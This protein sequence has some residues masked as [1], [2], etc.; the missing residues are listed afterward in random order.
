MSKAE[1]LGTDDIGALLLKQGLPASIG[2]LTLSIYFIV[3]TI[4]V[5][6]Y[7]GRLGIA[8]ITVVL[9]ITFLISSVGMA[10]GVGGATII[11]RA[12]G[13]N[14]KEKAQL[15]LGNQLALSGILG[16]LFVLLFF[17]FRD[18]LLL[19]FG[20]QGAIMPYAKTYFEVLI[21][22]VFPL[23]FA[24]ML[25]NVL[26]AEGK[27]KFAMLVMIAP[28]VTNVA[29]DFLFIAYFEWGI[30]GA[31]WATNFAYLIS[32]SMAVFFFVS[33]RTELYPRLNDIC[34]EGKII[35][36]IISI[37]SIT[38]ARQATISLLSL[39]LNNS[40][41]SLGGD[42]AVATWGIINRSMMFAIFPVLGVTQGF[43]PIV[44]Y[45][46]GAR[47]WA[48]VREVINKA[49]L[50]AFLLGGI[51]MLGIYYF[52]DAIAP[53]FSSDQPLIEASPN[54]I[55]LCFLAVPLVG[56][57]LISSAYFQAIGK[58]FPALI[59]TL[60]RQGFL[61]IPLLLL[62]PNFFG[63]NGIWYSFPL[64]DSLSALICFA[65]L[66]LHM[67]RKVAIYGK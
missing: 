40:L 59:L 27:A 65:Y 42:L 3:D 15:V 17:L 51:S 28:A 48:R 23:V 16:L 4:F 7:V 44:G 10:I 14:D 39:I 46:Y 21:I 26:R 2:I 41:F 1:E 18:Q 64:A 20:A 37:G 35:M 67:K 25:N 34:L 8:A 50:A 24:M 36:E 54:A 19:L 32:A 29:L 52:A 12:L 58:A 43:L 62:L 66:R 61:L 13:V 33:G 57:Q 38:L 55:R 11:S 30:A 6:H 47:Q 5:G 56:I 53:L 60:M 63:L 9:P 45:N 31:A 22:G 49:M